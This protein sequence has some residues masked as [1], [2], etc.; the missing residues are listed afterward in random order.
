MK[1]SNYPNGWD[2]ERIK[3]VLSHYENQSEDE[4][5][6]EDEAVMEGV[7]QNLFELPAN[8]VPHV[9][10]PIARRDFPISD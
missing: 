10:K 8:L 6:A 4:A 5:I 3:R 1:Q 7:S 9:R 2:E